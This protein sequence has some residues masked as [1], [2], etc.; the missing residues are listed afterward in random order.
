M[1]NSMK[2]NIGLILGI[3]GS[4]IA[5]L[6]AMSPEDMIDYIG[7]VAG[8]AMIGGYAFMSWDWFES[9]FGRDASIALFVP[10]LVIFGALAI[11]FSLIAPWLAPP[12]DKVVLGV[13]IGLVVVPLVSFWNIMR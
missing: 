6:S 12:H 8:V 11:G 3:V 4:G 10:P 13:G 9:Y 5:F 1:E 2:V 7:I